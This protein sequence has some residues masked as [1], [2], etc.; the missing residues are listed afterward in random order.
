MS[1]IHINDVSGSQTSGHGSSIGEF[2]VSNERML[3]MS[4]RPPAIL[5][6]VFRL[7]AVCLQGH[8]IA[9]M[10]EKTCEASMGTDLSCW[11][12]HFLGTL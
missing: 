3:Y 7:L 11:G 5:G 12:R 4:A 10:P 6:A 2:P 9:I 8:R 1:T